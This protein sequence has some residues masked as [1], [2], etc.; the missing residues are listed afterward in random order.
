MRIVF[1]HGR[2]QQRK[3]SKKLQ[4]EWEAAWKKGLR[5]AKI[6]APRTIDAVL[7]Y[8]GDRLVD[9]IKKIEAP[10]LVDII[11][12]GGS[13]QS[14]AARLQ[15]QMMYEIA[16]NA[17][18][19]DQKIQSYYSGE[20][21]ER[22]L[23]NTAWVRAIAKALDKTPLRGRVVDLVTHDVSVYL[24]NSGVRSQVDRIVEKELD[25]SPCVVVAHSLGTV[26]AYNV[27]FN[28]SAALDVRLFVT[29]G[30][31][32]GLNA[33]KNN[34]DGPLAKPVCVSRWFNARDK[35]DIVAAVPLDSKHFSVSPP[36]SNKSD[37]DNHTS[38]RHGI[39]GYLDDPE[40]ARKI[41]Q[42]LTAK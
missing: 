17:G 14:K 26:V 21:Q 4:S 7:P 37:V 3:N 39:E 11:T 38:N 1:I 40:V 12:R 9:L 16:R 25:Q 36:I 31:P 35:R 8:F 41:F 10:L 29:V 19:T 23:E 24:T 22:G 18:L 6:P 20:P 33:V 15:T 5:L 34:L 13:L 27:L 32:L 42:A 2:A 30:S 28:A